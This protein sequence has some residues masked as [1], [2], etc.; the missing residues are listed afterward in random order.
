M[1]LPTRDAYATS[2]PLIISQ[3][4]L[5]LV[6]LSKKYHFNVYGVG[7]V[8]LHAELQEDICV[9]PPIDFCL[10]VGVDRVDMELTP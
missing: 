5:L 1:R 9:K 10:D 4:L 2:P 8:F 7:A 3:R 6:G